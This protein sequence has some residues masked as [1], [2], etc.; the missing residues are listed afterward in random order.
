MAGLLAGL[1]TVLLAGFF[2]QESRKVD[3]FYRLSSFVDV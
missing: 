2:L 3:S 1:A